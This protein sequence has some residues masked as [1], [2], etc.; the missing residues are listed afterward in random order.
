MW[1]CETARGLRRGLSVGIRKVGIVVVAAMLLVGC[2][3]PFKGMAFDTEG[4]AAMPYDV[5]P[6][7]FEDKGLRKMR[8]VTGVV[9]ASVPPETASQAI[10]KVVTKDDWAKLLG[11]PVGLQVDPHS[12]YGGCTVFSDHATLGFMRSYNF[13][14]FHG[15]SA[16]DKVDELTVGGRKVKASISGTGPYDASVAFAL[17]PDAEKPDAKRID[18][19]DD[20]LVMEVVHGPTAQ[21]D[22]QTATQ[23]LIVKVLERIIPPLTRTDVAVPD[24]DD[25]GNV[26]FGELPIELPG[27]MADAP[28]ALRAMELCTA[29]LHGLGLTEQAVEIQT[30][31]Q[32]WCVLKQKDPNLSVVLYLEPD[33]I[34]EPQ[35]DPVA[36]RK[37]QSKDPKQQIRVLMQDSPASWLTV[38]S[39]GSGDPRSVAEKIVPLLLNPAWAP[40]AHACSHWALTWT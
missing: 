15:K 1:L 39:S 23:H 21:Y 9:L 20:V 11:G 8:P 35:I 16:G 22:K 6:A 29:A 17:T 40:R 5:Q 3:K 33:P 26:K 4:H 10:C 28:G 18:G 32:G 7:K 30:E 27:D 25:K 14:D 12:P 31:N 13:K 19:R 36:G 2:S 37:A 34:D 24:V 38:S